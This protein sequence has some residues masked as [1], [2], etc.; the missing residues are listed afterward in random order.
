MLAF[1]PA[2]SRPGSLV[3]FPRPILSL[4]VLD[5]WDFKKFKVPLSDGDQVK[6]HSRDGATIQIE[7]QI[8]SHSGSLKL[9]EVEML[10][11]LETIRQQLDVNAT[12]GELSL[13]LFA[14]QPNNQFRYF[15]NCTTS[16]FEFDLSNHHLYAYSATLHAADPVLH[17]GP[18]P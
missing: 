12:V 1:Q 17:S 11:T 2:I 9:T 13:V 5:A 3:E 15:Q 14:D 4:R 18:L 6:G 16:R 8:G 10:S 7:G